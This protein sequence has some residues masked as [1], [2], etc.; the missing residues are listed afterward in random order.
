MP[1][2]IF[3]SFL[4]GRRRAHRLRPI[5]EPQTAGTWLVMGLGNPGRDY[6]HNRHN[7]GFWCVNRLARSYRIALDSRTSLATMGQGHIEGRDAVLAKPRT[8]VNNSGDAAAALVRRFRVL[9]ERL[10]VICDSLDLP[11]G[12]VRVRARGSHGGH[13]GLKSITDRLGVDA[14]PRIRIGIG[15]PLVAGEPSW[16]PEAVAEYVLSDPPPSERRALDEA[17]ETVIAAVACIL[18][19]GVEAAMNRFN[20]ESQPGEPD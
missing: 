17:T 10:L 18:E 6:A 2:R 13:K 11:V 5:D 20:R 7:V 9:P 19:Q 16:D 15:R 12:A 1:S 3:R 14:F 8:Y 4:A